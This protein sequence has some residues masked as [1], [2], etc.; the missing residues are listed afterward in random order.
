MAGVKV[1]GVEN[2]IARMRAFNK[3][4]YSILQKEVRQASDLIGAEAR[5]NTP[6]PALS[7]WG[8]WGSSK[9][10]ASGF[11]N[12]SGDRPYDGGR[13]AKSIKP[14]FRT[15][16]GRNGNLTVYG[17]VNLNDAAGAIFSL[18]GKRNASGS[19]F[20]EN[21][22]RKYGTTLWPRLLTPAWHNNIDKA[23]EAMRAAVDRAAKA[24][25]GG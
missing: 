25:T 7:N 6:N 2:V 10:G 19:V 17:R 22:N 16:K 12:T 11:R 14:A 18:A 9:A 21:V 5:A 1:D 24:V 15:G 20:N 4:V 13:V 8:P 3:D 23:T